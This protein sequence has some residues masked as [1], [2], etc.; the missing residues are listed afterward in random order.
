MISMRVSKRQNFTTYTAPEEPIDPDAWFSAKA[1]KLS[2]FVSKVSPLKGSEK[3]QQ[4][5][6]VLL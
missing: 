2:S 1:G 4:W 6:S 3:R 5:F